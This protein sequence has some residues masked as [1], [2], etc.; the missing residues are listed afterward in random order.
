M[1][2]TCVPASRCPLL[3]SSYLVNPNSILIN[4]FTF[5]S[6]RWYVSFLPC[7]FSHSVGSRILFLFLSA[8][9]LPSHIILNF[10][11]SSDILVRREEFVGE[12]CRKRRIRIEESAVLRLNGGGLQSPVAECVLR[13]VRAD[14]Q[15][16]R[17]CSS[18]FQHNLHL[19]LILGLNY[20]PPNLPPNPLLRSPPHRKLLL[21]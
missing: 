14:S 20:H 7:I 17:Q 2:K 16:N 19:S 11:F 15:F 21:R 9:A 10:F 3:C 18:Y 8:S 4:S 5:S 6:F 12:S 13:F 1:S